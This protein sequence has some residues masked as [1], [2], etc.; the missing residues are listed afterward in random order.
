MSPRYPHP[1]KY[2]V[3]FLSI[4]FSSIIPLSGDTAPV[5]MYQIQGIT[6]AS[7]SEEGTYLIVGTDQV[8]FYIFEKYCRYR[9]R[10]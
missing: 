7:M 3:F 6:S 1:E 8:Y 10:W 5:W 4:L 9:C 2:Y